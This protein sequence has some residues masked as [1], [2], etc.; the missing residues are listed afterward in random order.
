MC[1]LYKIHLGLYHLASKL[2]ISNQSSHCMYNMAKVVVITLPFQ[3]KSGPLSAK[4]TGKS[5]R[6]EVHAPANFLPPLTQET[7]DTLQL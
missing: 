3:I 4:V 6:M 7:S 2:W 5:K 1:P